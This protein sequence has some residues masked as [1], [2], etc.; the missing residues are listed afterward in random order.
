MDTICFPGT[1]DSFTY[2]LQLELGSDASGVVKTLFNTL[3]VMRNYIRDM[4]VT[5]SLDYM[6]QLAFGIRYF[7]ARLMLDGETGLCF[8]HSLKTNIT[9]ADA[10][11]QTR[12]LLAKADA[13]KELVIWKVGYKGD[14]AQIKARMSQSLGV[15]PSDVLWIES[16]ENV[17]ALCQKTYGDVVA[18]G[19]RYILI[20]DDFIDSVYESSCTSV[21]E[22][23]ANIMSA[24]TKTRAAPC[25]PF[26]PQCILPISTSD[27]VLGGLK[28]LA[29]NGLGVFVGACVAL[30]GIFS[31]LLPWLAPFVAAGGLAAYI[32]FKASDYATSIAEVQSR[33]GHDLFEQYYNY[34]QMTKTESTKAMVMITDFPRDSYI[35]KC[36]MISSAS[37]VC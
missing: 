28:Y 9:F 15:E 24:S 16:A 4:A 8:T 27:Y 31:I 1:H 26:E 22:V 29:N 23:M 3:P 18:G 36:K 6:A 35:E 10:L 20:D 17:A 34:I 7:D 33:S 13:D 32:Y 30:V 2:D 12:T 21:S 37:V 19:R 5:Q 25:L 11:G 14:K